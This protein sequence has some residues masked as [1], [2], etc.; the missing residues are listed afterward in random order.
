MID[1]LS[2]SLN[3]TVI[4]SERTLQGRLLT[5]PDTEI[6]P[7]LTPLCVVDERVRRRTATQGASVREDEAQVRGSGSLGGGL[8][9]QEEEAG[10]GRGEEHTRRR[11]QRDE[12]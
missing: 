5:Y 9:D 6:K 11:S 12:R 8:G 4:Y 10:G 3:L 1:N 7:V 2:S